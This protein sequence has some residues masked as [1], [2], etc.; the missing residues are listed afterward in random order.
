MYLVRDVVTGQGKHRLDVAWHLGQDMQLVEAGLFRVKS[1]SQG[2]MLLPPQGHGWAEEVSRESWSPVYG[3]KAAMTTMNFGA[4]TALPAEFAIMLVTLEEAHRGSASFAKLVGVGSDLGAH[5]Y[6]YAR[7]QSE[8]CFV[9]GER[10]K[11]WQMGSI[12]SDAEFVCLHREA[13][14]VVENLILCGG[15]FAR[16]DGGPELRCTRPVEWA[17]SVLKAGA[18]VV[19]SSDA[20]ALE[21]KAAELQPSNVVSERS[22]QSSERS[23]E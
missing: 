2:L 16:V 21:Q 1:A 11:S 6:R 18:R 7:E 23:S 19:F 9:F 5:G 14:S 8:Y 17:E 3:R 13:G 22:S 4:E 15:S 20:A 10:G 12:S